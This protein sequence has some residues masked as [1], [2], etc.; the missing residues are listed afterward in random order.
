ML[1]FVLNE[2]CETNDSFGNY[3]FVQPALERCK[4]LLSAGISFV[5]VSGKL[6]VAILFENWLNSRT[7]C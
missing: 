7:K 3:N 1:N 5:G 2:V 4:I 6:T